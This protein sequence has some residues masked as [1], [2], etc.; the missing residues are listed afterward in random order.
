MSEEVF[1]FQAEI[2]QLLSLIINAFYSNKDV[3][4]RELVSNA[5]D[6]LDKI[7]H[8]S[9]VEGTSVLGDFTDLAIRIE[10]NKNDN[11]LTIRDFGIGMTREELIKNLGTIAHSGTKAFMEALGDGLTDL[12]LIGQ[13]GMGFYSAYLVAD[14]VTVISKSND[15]DEQYAWEST[16]S[17]SF[18]VRKDDSEPLGRGTKMILHL[19]EDCKEYLE[20][21]KITEIINK[22]SQFINFPIELLVERD[23]EKE[24]EDETKTDVVIED[25]Q[26]T[27]NTADTKK[28]TITIK[29]H[30]WKQLNKQKPLWTRPV[31]DV[32]KEEY[33]SFYK[34]VFNDW[35]EHLAVKHFAAEG[36]LVFKS[37]L[38]VPKRVPFDLFQTDKKPDNMKLYVRRVFITDDAEQLCPTY[39]NFVKGIVDTDDLP[40][41]VSREMLQNNSI[42]RTIKKTIVKK[43]I[44]LFNE[45]AEDKEQ[46]KQF[47]QNYNKNL[48]MGIHDD[49]ANRD[50]LIELL[51]FYSSK[52]G[53]DMTSLKDYVTRMPESQKGIYYIT[54]ESQKAV[55]DSPFLERLRKK[56]YEVLYLVD[57][58]DE[59][60]IQHIREYEGKSLVCCTKDGLK[61]DDNE[62]SALKEKQ[63]AFDKVCAFMKET[64]GDKVESVKVSLRVVDSP[65]VLVTSEYG[66]TA[67]MER[68]IKAQALRNNEHFNYM[69]GRKILEINPDHKIMQELKRQIESDTETDKT[70]VTRMVHLIYNTSM[71][72]S[73][74][75][76]DEPSQYACTIFRL[77]E[78]GMSLEDDQESESV[79]ANTQD[80]E[81]VGEVQ[82]TMEEVD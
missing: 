73:G 27:E 67:N 36:Q 51:R 47:Y 22:H 33:A 69:V 59:Y 44:E 28:Q 15:S 72:N 1:V 32:T 41:N 61:L 62:E 8:K 64:L 78:S 71:L 21:T 55:K 77:M 39:L 30:E 68:I 3:F 34:G 23:V 20:E 60:M 19:K 42:V 16:A 45:L 11:T 5:S 4:L 7:R 49:H 57:P 46:Y 2:N 31:D 54:G 56:G 6:A 43:C 52:S 79:D 66:W 82:T 75:S 12:S 53:D 70:S 37:L 38:F 9:L 13:F 50:K 18:T 48:K 81:N 29:E 74:F 17:G 65:C 76:L 35:D 10:A 80:S 24:V 26:V 63:E 58:I 40:L 14:K 25:G